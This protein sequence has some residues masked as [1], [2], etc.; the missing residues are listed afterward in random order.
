MRKNVIVP[1]FL[2]ERIVEYFEDWPPPEW[3]ESRF[4]YCEL[5]WALELK[6]ERIKF[7]N[8][9]ADVILANAPYVFS[10]TQD[11]YPWQ[12]RRPDSPGGDDIPF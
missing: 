9:Y 1:A 7:K 5:L 6:L 2:L 3:H 11:D 8:S 12:R 10:K 4:E